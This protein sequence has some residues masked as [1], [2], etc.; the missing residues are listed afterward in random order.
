LKV[1]GCLPDVRKRTFNLQLS[2]CNWFNIL[3]M[4]LRKIMFGVGLLAGLVFLGAVV[5]NHLAS[6]P[7]EVATSGLAAGET[8]GGGDLPLSMGTNGLGTNPAAGMPQLDGGPVVP[9]KTT[10]SW[11]E[12]R[13]GILKAAIPTEEQANLFLAALPQLSA[14]EQEDAARHLVNLLGDEQFLSRAAAYVTNAQ[15]P[16][17]V[18][19]LFMADL[20]NR[21]E[22]VKLPLW[23]AVIRAPG[24]PNAEEAREL[25]SF[26]VPE[27]L[28]TNW[29]AWETA[30]QERLSAKP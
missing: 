19:A 4:S 9:P 20:L 22:N 15:A 16:Q 27:D 24:H 6:L 30:V 10:V 1:E 11:D 12:Q 21:P 25:L 26:Y 3:G 18:Q 8:S 5:W 13:D 28:G 23:L 7:P 17:A 2:T 14:T 29:P